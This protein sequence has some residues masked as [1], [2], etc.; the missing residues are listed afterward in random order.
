MTGDFSQL[1]QVFI[2]LIVNGIQAMPGGGE[3]RII[4]DYGDRDYVRVSIQDTG[5]GIPVE[6]MDKLFTPFFSTKEAVK[7]VGLG[8]AVSYG[9]VERHGGRIEVQSE[10]GK[11][12]DFSV[13]LP[14]SH[15][16]Q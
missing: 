7:G 9:I 5:V 2:N 8:L 10:V 13:F 11:G 4:S 14:A 16:G 6:N 15:E 1:Q 12:S 3:L